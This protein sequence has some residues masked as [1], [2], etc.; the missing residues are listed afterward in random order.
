[1]ENS[2]SKIFHML[3]EYFCLLSIIHRVD[4]NKFRRN[5]AIDEFQLWVGVCVCGGDT[6]LSLV[7]APLSMW[8]KGVPHVSHMLDC[9]SQFTL[10]LHMSY[11][12]L[13]VRIRVLMS[14]VLHMD[15]HWTHG[16]YCIVSWQ[17]IILQMRQREWEDWLDC[18]CWVFPC[19]HLKTP[20]KTKSPNHV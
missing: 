7:W 5:P 2:K 17:R 19:F 6:Q 13:T 3:A 20:N 15:W 10:Y 18:V 14:D 8:L 1:M 4:Q 9:I 12:V 11:K 16:V